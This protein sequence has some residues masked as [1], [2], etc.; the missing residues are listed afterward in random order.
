MDEESGMP[1]GG[2]PEDKDEDEEG[3]TI[4]GSVVSPNESPNDSDEMTGM[5]CISAM[6]GSVD[7]SVDGSDPDDADKG[8]D[9]TTEGCG[10][11]M[12]REDG[13]DEPGRAV[14]LTA[15]GAEYDAPAADSALSR[16][17]NSSSWRFGRKVRMRFHVR[18][19]STRGVWKELAADDAVVSSSSGTDED[20]GGLKMPA[21]DMT[22]SM[23]L[24]DSGTA[25]ASSS[26]LP[27]CM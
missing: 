19:H 16:P 12:L 9:T 27:A 24:S 10:C 23:F 20:D 5:V 2:K 21:V 13:G 3:G 17:G 22:S 25:S 1:A 4:D 7:C 8:V 26:L 6:G 14:T 11:C 18:S 15:A